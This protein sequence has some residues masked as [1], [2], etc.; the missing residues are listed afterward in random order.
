MVKRGEAAGRTLFL[1]AARPLALNTEHEPMT[2]TNPRSTTKAVGALSGGAGRLLAC[3]ALVAVCAGSAHAQVGGWIVTNLHPAGATESRVWST[4]GMQQ[5]GNALFGDVYRAGIWNGTAASWVNLNPAG[6]QDSE[7]LATS[8]TQQ[9]GYGSFAG[10]RAGIWNGT[11]AS[12]VDLNP[13]GSNYSY[14][15]A[16]SG[17][18]QGGIAQI[19]DV[20]GA[21]IWSGTAASFI[22]LN[23]AGA[24]FSQVVGTTG[25][26]QVGGATIDGVTRAGIWSGTAASW[27]DLSPAGATHSFATDTTGTQQVGGAMFGSSVVR[28]GIWSGTAASWVDLTPA[29]ALNSAAI[30][31]TGTQQAGYATIGGVPRP[32][33]WSGTAASWEALP[34]PLTGSWSD[35]YAQSIWS[36]ATTLYV[37]GNG[38]NNSTSQIEAL[39]WTRPICRADFNHSGG[40]APLTV[41]DI[42]DFLTAWFAQDPRA[43]FNGVNFITAQDIFDFLAAWFTGC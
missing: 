19:G 3:A 36:D 11:A 12:W 24:N 20:Y 6:S 2:I 1:I 27:V 29:G 5:A 33:I 9:A 25:T 8:G 17:T 39:L 40:P 10:P 26:Q 21:A 23:P 16:T 15:S 35:S 18:Q 38:F 28:A 14:A 13:E 30:A 34:T 31:T 42:F 32:C 7:A 37:A 41:Q 4:R 43:D 22:N